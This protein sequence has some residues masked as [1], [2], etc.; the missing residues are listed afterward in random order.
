[1]GRLNYQQRLLAYERIK[2]QIA[3]TA[4]T[5]AEYERRVTALARKLGI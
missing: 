1:M 5:P 2:K 4:T 3:A